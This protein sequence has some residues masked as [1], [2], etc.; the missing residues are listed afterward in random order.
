MKRANSQP[1]DFEINIELNGVLKCL[2]TSIKET[3]DGVEYFNCNINDRNITQ[4]RREKDGNWEQI[5]GNLTPHEVDAIGAAINSK[6]E[7]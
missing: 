5:W 7:I 6:K 2:K 4:I 1:A 3:T